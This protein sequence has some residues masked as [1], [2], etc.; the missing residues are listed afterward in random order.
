MAALGWGVLM[1]KILE[2]S[3]AI[4][5]YT[6]HC[7]T[8]VLRQIEHAARHTGAAHLCIDLLGLCSTPDTWHLVIGARCLV[9]GTLSAGEM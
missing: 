4:I 5:F 3:E 8:G 1:I 6:S 7:T 9:L 2:L